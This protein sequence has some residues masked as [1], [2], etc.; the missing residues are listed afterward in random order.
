M[1]SLCSL[2]SWHGAFG[3]LWDLM[4][5]SKGI[6]HIPQWEGA[7]EGG[8]VKTNKGRQLQRLMDKIDRLAPSA[9]M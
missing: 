6:L 2:R 4:A 1:R 5:E 3:K 7:V 9:S 8:G